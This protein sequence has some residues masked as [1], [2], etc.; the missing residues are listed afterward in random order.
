MGEKGGEVVNTTMTSKPK[1]LTVPQVA[2][3]IGMSEQWV[4][5]HTAAEDGS[6]RRR[7]TLPCVRF[8]RSIRYREDQIEQFIAE[9][10]VS[11]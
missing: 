8:G 7:P 6:S 5:D 4:R 3:R 2:E 1:L 9:N 11:A 10:T